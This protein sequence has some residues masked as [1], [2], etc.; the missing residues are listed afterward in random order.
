[1]F[2]GSSRETMFLHDILDSKIDINALSEFER[3]LFTIAE[4]EEECLY[5]MQQEN[6]ELEEYQEYINELYEEIKELT[7]KQGV[8]EDIS[9]ITEYQKDKV[10]FFDELVE[11]KELEEL[12]LR[13]VTQL[14]KLKTER[15]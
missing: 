7:K 2:T 14:L 4:K 6:E 13:D 5:N 12:P 10:N 15:I 9:I 8:A 3:V 11:M 1:M